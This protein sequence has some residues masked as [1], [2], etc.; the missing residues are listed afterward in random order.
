MVNRKKV[1]RLL[2]EWGF[3][4]RGAAAAPGSPRPTV[5]HHRIQRA[6]ADRPDQRLVRRGRLG[7][8]HR[9]IDCFDRSILGW[10]FTTRCRATDVSPALERAWAAAWPH[11]PEPGETITV[12]CRRDNGTQFTAHYYRDVAHGLGVRLSRTAYRHPDGNAFMERLYRTL[13]EEGVWPNDFTSFNQAC[14][15]SRP[16][17]RTTTTTGRTTRSGIAPQPKR[18]HRPRLPGWGRQLR[19]Y[20][21]A[22]R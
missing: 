7:P 22:Q 1:A 13:Q 16:G 3:T 21:P 18:E 14:R 11:G 8:L 5:Q 12:V 6:V 19:F 20:S 4:R 10:T 9:V 15:P 17:S 2:R